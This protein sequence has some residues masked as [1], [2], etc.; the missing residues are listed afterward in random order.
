MLLCGFSGCLLAAGKDG[1]IPTSYSSA[2][3]VP[4]PAV[5]PGNGADAATAS[6][7]HSRLSAAPDSSR[8]AV[9]TEGEGLGREDNFPLSATPTHTG[10]IRVTGDPDLIRDEE[11]Y[12]I[13]SSAT[14]PLSPASR[15]IVTP[16]C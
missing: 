6:R 8:P 14:P 2:S 9:G 4:P 15:Y 16:Y 3:D 11:D 7:A 10:D 5:A 1:D 12:V 13:P